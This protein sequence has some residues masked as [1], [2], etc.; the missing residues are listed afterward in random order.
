MTKAQGNYKTMTG[1]SFAVLENNNAIWSTNTTTS[2]KVLNAKTIIGEIE[3]L[4]K[5][6]GLNLKGATGT[7][8]SSWLV[9]AKSA[10]HV[11]CGLKA[12]YDDKEDKTN[13]AIINFSYT[14]LATCSID[15]AIKRMELIQKKAEG[16]AIADLLDFK[17][18][19]ADI[20]GLNVDILALKK[21]APANAVL[22]V[23]NKEITAAINAKFKLLKPCMRKLDTNINIYKRDQPDFVELYSFSRRTKNIG[24]GHLTAEG[25]IMPEHFDIFLGKKISI[26]DVLTVRNH[27]AFDAKITITDTPEI[28]ELDMLKELPANDEV[29]FEVPKDFNGL[30]GHWVMV[31]N[32]NKFDDVSVTIL[33]A[34]A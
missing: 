3:A 2:K 10:D 30:F 20:T 5:Q 33:V 25:D 12:Y 6:H 4:E 22:Q 17:V 27:S 32:P 13:L 9:A 19:A 14:E 24:K 26:G 28:L 7:K 29:K 18:V 11:N 34:K 23:T 31:Y 8:N 15:D 21:D 16:I 1:V